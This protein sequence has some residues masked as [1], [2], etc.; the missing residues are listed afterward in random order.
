M[1]SLVMITNITYAQ[2]NTLDPLNTRPGENFEF[3]KQ[4]KKLNELKS[5]PLAAARLAA[6]EIIRQQE[7]ANPQPKSAGT[8]YYIPVVFHVLHM[9]GSENISDEQIYDAIRVLN[10]DFSGSNADVD[11]PEITPSVFSFDFTRVSV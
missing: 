4:H 8:I 1:L 5:N 11:E 10:E 6:D 3:C 7:L 2:K 9:N